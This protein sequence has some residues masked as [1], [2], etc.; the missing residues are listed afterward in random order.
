MGASIT[1]LV[2]GEVAIEQSDPVLLVAISILRLVRVNGDCHE[3]ASRNRCW[4]YTH[5]RVVP[6]RKTAHM[7]LKGSSAS[8][9]KPL[10]IFC[11]SRSPA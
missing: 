5:H 1:G 10:V 2:M 4:I 8:S 6:A 9:R 7:G 3:S 11:N